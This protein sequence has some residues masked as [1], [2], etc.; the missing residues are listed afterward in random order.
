MRN[1]CLLFSAALVQKIAERVDPE[2]VRS[3]R[4]GKSVNVVVDG[5]GN[6]DALVNIVNFDLVS[7][8]KSKIEAQ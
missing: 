5:H 8:L 3:V 7:K 2:I 4:I 1:G 6:F